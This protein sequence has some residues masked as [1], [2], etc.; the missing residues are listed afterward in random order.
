MKI[1]IISDPHIG[2]YS[3]GKTDIETGLNTRL[4]DFLY[5][6]D[7]TINY[8]IENDVKVYIIT[9]DIY[10]VKHPNSKI[11]KQF[12]PR[13]KKLLKNNIRVILLTGNH[14][15]TT[16]SDG[17]HALSEMQELCDL[18][19][20]FEVYSSSKVIKI[21]DDT[22]LYILPF[23]NRGIEKLLT[24]EE[25][26]SF[27]KDKIH[28]FNNLTKESTSKNKL[29]FGHFGTDQSVL[30]ASFDL[31][32]SSNENE[33]I[34]P[35]AIF[36]EGDWTKVY[37]GHIHKQQEFNTISRHVGSLGRVDFAEEKEQK[38][39]Y[40][41]ENGTD[42]FIP[43]KDREFKTFKINL[44]DENCRKVLL[45]FFEKIKSLDLKNTIVR[46]KAD[47]LQTFLPILKFDEIESYLRENSWHSLGVDTNLITVEE[48]KPK[49][50]I[51]TSDTPDNALKKHIE[52]HS[53]RFQGIEE[54]SL[55]SGIEILKMV[56][57]QNG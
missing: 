27:Q 19:N 49:Q 56:I 23:V 46:V 20:E 13:I 39:F 12:A 50:E 21:D 44:T 38:G 8:A 4:L 28:E 43:I 7:Q 29:F 53:E 52:M 51:T 36:D 40:L 6:L 54:K 25:F 35:L 14:D 41:F 24:E 10:R 17:A 15:M 16:S 26:I 22:E 47:V 18:I 34:I 37:L 45:N 11:R 3:Y 32:M 57:Q 33:N 42:K 1:A 5:N 55:K 2:D 48:D 9:G 31:D 30:G